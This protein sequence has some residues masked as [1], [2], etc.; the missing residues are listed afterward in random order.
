[1]LTLYCI[2]SATFSPYTKQ[3]NNSSQLNDPDRQN[4]GQLTIPMINEG[5]DN[6]GSGRGQFTLGQ[7]LAIPWLR[8]FRGL[9]GVGVRPRTAIRAETGV[10][11]LDSVQPCY[12]FSVSVSY[13][14]FQGLE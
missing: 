11:V 9:P 1:M 7:G 3:Q 13:R 10:A 4:L 8:L 12:W 2:A 5:Q 14:T 6:S